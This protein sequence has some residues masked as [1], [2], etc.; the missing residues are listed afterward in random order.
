MS[1]FYAV[2]GSPEWEE[3]RHCKRKTRFAEPPTGQPGWL[4]IYRCKFCGGFHLTS[5]PRTG[6]RKHQVIEHQP[7]PQGSTDAS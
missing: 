7:S 5:K 6:R 3:H 4:R 1:E 2:K